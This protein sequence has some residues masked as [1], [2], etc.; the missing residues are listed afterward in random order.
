MMKNSIVSTGSMCLKSALLAAAVLTV[1]LGANAQ[2]LDLSVLETKKEERRTIRRLTATADQMRL[3][4]EFSELRLALY[5]PRDEALLYRKLQ[6]DYLTAVSAA[7]EY[8]NLSVMIN[9]QLVGDIELTSGEQ[10]SLRSFDL[11]PGLIVEGFNE[12]RFVARH[13]HRVDCTIPATYELWTV[14]NPANTGLVFNP[15]PDTAPKLVSGLEVLRAI[16]NDVTGSTNF[17][18]VQPANMSTSNLDRSLAVAQTVAVFGKYQNPNIEIRPEPGTNAG[19][20]IIV[21]TRAEL[22]KAGYAVGRTR[23]GIQGLALMRNP[24]TG[25]LSLLIAADSRPALDH[26]IAQFQEA[27]A[28][29]PTTGTKRGIQVF[30]NKFG[31]EITPGMPV[32]LAELGVSSQRF[33]GRLMQRDFSIKLPEDYF[34]GDYGKATLSLD[35]EALAD[36]SNANRLQVFANGAALASAEL[37]RDGITSRSPVNIPLGG[38]SPGFNELRI[39]VSSLTSEDE[40]CDVS[41]LNGPDRLAFEAST[42]TIE[43][44]SLA[45]M[46][47]T[48]SVSPGNLLPQSTADNRPTYIQVPSNDRSSL[49]AAAQLAVATAAINQTVQPVSIVLGAGDVGS[50]PG[51]IVAPVNRLSGPA[52]QAYTDTLQDTRRSAARGHV[53]NFLGLETPDANEPGLWADLRRYANSAWRNMGFKLGSEFQAQQSFKLEKND[54]LFSQRT[55]DLSSQESWVAFFG[56]P[57]KQDVWTVVT[58]LTGDDVKSGVDTLLREGRLAWLGGDTSLYKTSDNTVLSDRFSE[59]NYFA[60]LANPSELRNSRLVVAGVISHNMLDFVVFM[61]LFGVVLAFSYYVA[62]R[63]SGR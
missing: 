46:R 14:L 7:P 12:V 51:L 49:E 26:A 63:K 10:A 30:T 17:R 61:V 13:K 25:R 43:F 45:R 31:Y 16:P 33:D 4:G 9:G 19:M 18:L 44:D 3:E 53:A 29:L 60:S 20:D 50:Q 47:V 32:S 62:L 24:E 28:K 54:V 34:V 55:T 21:G 48:P 1:P 6:V 37:T 8:S 58:G 15:G 41:S 2:Q 57:V 35:I 27:L 40:A 59:A 36:L 5:A 11:P 22:S 56:A 52:K 42:S 38:F 39:E 23:S